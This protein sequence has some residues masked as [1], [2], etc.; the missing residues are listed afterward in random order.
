MKLA[1]STFLVHLFALL[2]WPSASQA[3]EPFTPAP[4]LSERFQYNFRQRHDRGFYLRLG[5]GAGYLDASIDAPTEEA[6]RTQGIR[7]S[8]ALHTG[9]FVKERLVLGLAQFSQLSG[10]RG[11]LH[12][13]PA[14]TLYFQED[15]NLFIGAA[16]GAQT[17]YDTS[18][19]IDPLRQ[20]GV[21]GEVELGTGWWVGDHSH[22]GLSF[23]T[24][25]SGFDL[26]QD[27]ITGQGWHVG[28]R[29]TVGLN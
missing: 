6:L 29:A 12:A 19:N 23:A 26:D 8:Y 11:L 18:A 5:A 27:S 14:A 17:F 4:Q 22:L 1:R 28:L 3:G 20:W 15:R 2:A 10:T 21:G 9:F 13:G 16:L 24:G 7:L 25:I